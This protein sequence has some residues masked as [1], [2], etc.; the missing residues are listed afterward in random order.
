MLRTALALRLV[1]SCVSIYHASKNVRKTKSLSDVAQ[2]H[3]N[4]TEKDK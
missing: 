4:V 3:H 1:Q 2:Q